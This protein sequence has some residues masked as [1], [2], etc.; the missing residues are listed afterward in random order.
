MKLLKDTTAF[1]NFKP[2]NND[3]KYDWIIK[4]GAPDKI[5]PQIE[6]PMPK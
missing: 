2:Q 3:V 5:V 6:P 4:N 1:C